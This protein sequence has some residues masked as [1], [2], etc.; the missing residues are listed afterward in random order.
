MKQTIL[1][2][3]KCLRHQSGTGQPVSQHVGREPMAKVENSLGSQYYVGVDFQ[4]IEID[5]VQLAEWEIAPFRILRVVE[6]GVAE[7]KLFVIEF[8]YVPVTSADEEME[9]DNFIIGV[10][11]INVIKPLDFSNIVNKD[12][13]CF[14]KS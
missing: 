7:K 11:F 12:T 13:V 2:K 9:I 5:V 14:D 10:D 3:S 1:K 4:T 8:S 6:N